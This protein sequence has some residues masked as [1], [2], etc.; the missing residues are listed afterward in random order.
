MWL[1]PRLPIF[2]CLISG[3]SQSKIEWSWGMHIQSWCEARFEA[4]SSVNS[5]STQDV[6]WLLLPLT[7]ECHLHKVIS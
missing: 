7:L 5:Q 2:K 6:T 3:K 4:T 1:L